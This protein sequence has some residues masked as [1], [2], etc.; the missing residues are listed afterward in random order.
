MSL[1]QLLTNSTVS[2]VA[3]V[4]IEPKAKIEGMTLVSGK[5]Y[6][7]E[8]S[9]N[10]RPPVALYEDGE[11]LTVKTSIADVES[12]SGSWYWD[13]SKVYVHTTGSDA[14]SGYLI[15]ITSEYRFSAAQV[16]LDEWNGVRWFPR[17]ARGKAPI[18]K[19]SIPDIF[20][21]TV[22]GQQISFTLLNSDGFFDNISRAYYWENSKVTVR[23]GLENLSWSDFQIGFIGFLQNP[24]WGKDEVSFSAIDQRRL[25]ADEFIPNEEFSQEDYSDLSDEDEGESI[26]AYFGPW[27]KVPCT[28]IDETAST[29]KYK[30]CGHRIESIEEVQIGGAATSISNYS[31][32]LANGE[33]TL[34]VDPGSDVVTASIKGFHNSTKYVETGIEQALEVVKMST[35]PGSLIDDTSFSNAA[36]ENPA[37]TRYAFTSKVNIAT[38]LGQ[39]VQDTF[40]ILDFN[41]SGQLQAETWNPQVPEDAPILREDRDFISEPNVS[42]RTSEIFQKIVVLYDADT[43]T[44]AKRIVNESQEAEILLQRTRTKEIN[45]GLISSADAAEASGRYLFYAGSRNQRLSC[46]VG[47]RGMQFSLGQKVKVVYSRGSDLSGELDEKTFEIIDIQ[48]DLNDFLVTLTLEDMKG[49]GSDIAFWAPDTAVDWSSSSEPERDGQG[50][51]GDADGFVDSEKTRK[52][53]ML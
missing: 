36:A 48:K 5:L 4:C 47:P 51:W 11:E 39:I 10:Y 12:N 14:P 6:T 35:L 21:S 49:L 23:W 16:G 9:W 42:S 34:T 30:I 53:V 31:T 3:L 24:G 43:D 41:S 17:I 13:G 50:Y 20:S 32:D 22:F 1:A 8:K 37:K 45:T 18:L 27:A 15:H 33:F 38:A 26:P 44:E 2:P 46:Q 28:L 29:W 19:D 52:K 25:F 7:Y 40:L